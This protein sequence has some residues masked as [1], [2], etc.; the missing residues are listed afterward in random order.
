[1]WGLSSVGHKSG[2]LVGHAHGMD[3]LAER[4]EM[5]KQRTITTGLMGCLVAAAALVP[6]ALPATPAGAT[7][8]YPGETLRLVQEAPAVQGHETNWVASGQQA[9]VNDYAGGFNL[10]VFAKDTNVDSSCSPSYLGEEQAELGDET[11][12]LQ[13]VIGIWQGPGTTFSVPFRYIFPMTGKVTLCAYSVYITDTAAAASLVVGISAASSPATTQ[14]VT[15]AAVKPV[16]TA[17]PNISQSVKTLT[18]I[19]GSWRNAVSFAYAWLVNSKVRPSA[20][21]ET[22]PVT[23]TLKGHNVICRVTAYNSVWDTPASTR[24]FLV[25]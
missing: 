25:H 7:G 9:Q 10:E 11:H 1:M 19:R 22:L 8:A 6:M 14:P 2:S 20:T 18:C 24:S 5:S 13:I 21:D 3:I 17:L 16:N 12:E 23:S 15:P 4:T